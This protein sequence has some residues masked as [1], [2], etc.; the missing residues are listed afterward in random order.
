MSGAVIEFNDSI[1]ASQSNKMDQKENEIECSGISN[2][3]N[4]LTLAH[5]GLSECENYDNELFFC[6]CC[7]VYPE[8]GGIL[9]YR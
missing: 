2:R 3:L 6:C 7:S 8:M 5:E 1:R 9:V 4:E